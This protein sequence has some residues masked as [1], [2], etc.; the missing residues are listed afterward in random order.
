MTHEKK[1]QD[2][3]EQG[4]ITDYSLD[5]KPED[6]FSLEFVYD[7]IFNI[8]FRERWMR[9]PEQDLVSHAIELER[10]LYDTELNYQS[11]KVKDDS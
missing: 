8:H 2:K 5:F 7:M 4:E 9:V 3:S 1:M 6:G 10:E 11:I